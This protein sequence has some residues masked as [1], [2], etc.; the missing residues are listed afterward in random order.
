MSTFVPI[1]A[2]DFDGTLCEIQW[3]GIGAPNTKLIEHLIERRKRGAK[4]I[5]WTCRVGE[6]LQDAV[7][8]CRE[9]GL[10]FDAVND[11]LPEMIERYGNNCRKIY[12]TCYIDDLAVD[13]KKYGLPFHA[14]QRVDETLAATYPIGSEWVLMGDGFECP[15]KVTEI[16]DR[17][18]MI[19]ES[20]SDTTEYRY[21]KCRRKMEWFTDKLFP[22][23][24]EE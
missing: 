9:Q 6:R 16:S 14:E 18:D 10:E 7:D 12:A 3:P 2:V 1:Y 4:I 19:V 15:V 8:W 5:L 17:G 22:L 23:V 21:Y 20:I 24:K 11:N 13:K